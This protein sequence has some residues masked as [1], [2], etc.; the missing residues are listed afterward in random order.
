MVADGAE[1]RRRLGERDPPCAD[2]AVE[3]RGGSHL[4]RLIQQHAE[5]YVSD[6]LALIGDAAFGGQGMNWPIGRRLFSAK[7]TAT[8]HWRLPLRHTSNSAGR[9]IPAPSVQR[10]V[11]PG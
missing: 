4:Y 5:R 7:R 1:L 2:L 10:T 6:G 8:P 11:V 3:R 9:S